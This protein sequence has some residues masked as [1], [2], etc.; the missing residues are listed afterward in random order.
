MGP[1]RDRP[2]GEARPQIMFLGPLYKSFTDGGERAEQL[3]MQVAQ[4]LDRYRA[5]YGL[6]LWLETHAPMEQGGQRALRPLGSGVW[7]RWPEFGLSL[8]KD[9][10]NPMRVH[11]ERFR[12]DRDER[13]WPHFL[14]RSSPWPWAAGW[15]GG[16]PVEEAT[17]A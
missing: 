3:N 17:S 2:G 12:G 11:L 9:P 8:R 14:E 5:R 7:S 1:G 15:H 6:A 4:I 16:F 10:N 13:A